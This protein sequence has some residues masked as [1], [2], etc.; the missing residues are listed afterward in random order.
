MGIIEAQSFSCQLLILALDKRGRE[1]NVHIT[2]VG[3]VIGDDY[4]RDKE[5]SRYKCEAD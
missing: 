2:D 1:R 4:S 3:L 5:T